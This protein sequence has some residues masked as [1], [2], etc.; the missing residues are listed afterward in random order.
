[1]KHKTMNKAVSIGGEEA[2]QMIGGVLSQITMKGL[3]AALD[4]NEK[5]KR[6]SP[7]QRNDPNAHAGTNDMSNTSAKPL[8]R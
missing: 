4:E 6:K 8:N 1:M 3:P 7:R 5:Q 2:G